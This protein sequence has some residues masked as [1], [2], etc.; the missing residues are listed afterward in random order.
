MLLIQWINKDR[1]KR[2][3]IR[4]A[5]SLNVTSGFIYQLL[6]GEKKPGL[7][8]AN[9]IA[10]LTN[11]EVPTTVWNTRS[12]TRKTGKLKNIARG[13]TSETLPPNSL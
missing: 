12:K 1:K 3:V 6:R 7:E 8:K 10:A 5:Q 4:V 13:T 11:N 9:E 2:S